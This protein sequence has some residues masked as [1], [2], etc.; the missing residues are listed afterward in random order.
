MRFALI[1]AKYDKTGQTTLYFM[2]G[3]ELHTT[4]DISH[5]LRSS[6]QEITSY[7]KKYV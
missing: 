7:F 4:D 2:F 5:N 3:R 6:V 1:T